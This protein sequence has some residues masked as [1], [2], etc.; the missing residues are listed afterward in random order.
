MAKA[1]LYVLT[2]KLDACTGVGTGSVFVR[3]AWNV[4]RG[5]LEFKLQGTCFSEFSFPIFFLRMLIVCQKQLASDTD[6]AVTAVCINA[7]T[8]NEPLGPLAIRDLS[9]NSSCLQK[10]AC[11]ARLQISWGNVACATNSSIY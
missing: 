5:R 11:S 7:Y 4:S 1:W 3:Q 8:G 6:M 9:Q 10:I 2:G